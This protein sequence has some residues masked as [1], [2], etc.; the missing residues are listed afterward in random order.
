LRVGPMVAGVLPSLGGKS[1]STWEAYV[2]E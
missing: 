1:K 2:I